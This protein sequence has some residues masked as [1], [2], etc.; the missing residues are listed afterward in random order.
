MAA[1]PS[2]TATAG[3]AQ[4]TLNWIAS[5]GATGY[6]LKMSTNGGGNYSVIAGD[7]PG[8]TFIH[9]GLLAGTNYLYIVTALNPNG[10]S[11]ASAPA[12]AVP[13]AGSSAPPVISGI[14]IIGGSLVITG[15]NGTPGASYLVLTT[16]N[17]A[18]PPANWTILTTNQYGPGGGV[19]WT[20]PLN[21]N[22]PQTYYRLRL[23]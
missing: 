7:F 3:V 1:I 20:N 23:P 5:P 6:N 11:E 9:A 4:I 22:F 21:P 19:N 17:L 16:T 12:G 13:L 8:T 2:L 14:R 18:A 10:E 15:T